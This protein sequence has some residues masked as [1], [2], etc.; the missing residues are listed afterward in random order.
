MRIL[1]IHTQHAIQRLGTGVYG[2]YLRYA[3]I[4]MP[5]LAALVP[6]ELGAEV[7]V[8][9]EMVEAVDLDAKADL[10]GLTAITSA[11]PRAYE[12]ARHFRAR[13]AKVVL[14][15]V[16][17]T[18]MPDEASEHV[19]V[20]VQ[21]YAE[22]TWPRLLRDFHAG[23]L[24]RRYVH[25]RSVPL[26]RIATPDRSHI[27]A[28]RYV[29]SNTV[30]M[31]RGCNRR[32][33]YCVTHRLNE[34][35]VRR[36]PE[37]VLNEIR[38]L[39]GRL[40]TFLD[41]NVFGDHAHARALFTGL[42]ELEK[43]WVGCVTADVARHPEL[44]DLLVESGAR[45]FLVG[46]ESLSQEAL[47]GSNKAF[48]HVDEY[49]SAIERFHAKGV[50]VQGSFMFG[51]DADDAGVFDR[52]VDF[53][54]RARI[55]LPQFTVY[56]PFPGTP[57]FDTLDAAGRILTR[58]W[59]RYDGHQVVFRP[60]RM[61]PAELADGVRHAWRRAYALPSI[62]RRLASP[63]WRYKPVALL[64]NLNFRR[65]MRRVHALPAAATPGF[66]G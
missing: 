12:L 26:E 49:L 23:R 41:P 62:A 34:G 54:L 53:I 7:R 39:P 13:G 38:R 20:V 27:K 5:T 43:R 66:S 14:G 46:F 4:T 17:A 37:A 35:Y 21:G 33:H 59:S 44:L 16:H 51:F 15:G 52:T 24:Q 19:D 29:A 50:M 18:L 9:D 32:C 47:D 65:F 63:P 57:A 22:E 8:V 30:E 42:K 6:P 36:D 10:V 28:S 60:A 55:E 2:K 64:S 48:N 58:D 40:V 25:D 1:L 61:T 56:T 11:A 45:G 3:P 31:S